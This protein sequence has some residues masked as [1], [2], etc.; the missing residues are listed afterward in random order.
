MAMA[1]PTMLL[2]VVLASIKTFTRAESNIL[3]FGGGGIRA[4]IGT[5]IAISEMDKENLSSSFRYNVGLSGGTWGMAAAVYAKDKLTTQPK[6]RIDD[7]LDNFHHRAEKD[8]HWGEMKQM[9]LRTCINTCHA[10]WTDS[11]RLN[12]M[13][14][15]TNDHK[16]MDF[17]DENLSVQALTK[18]AKQVGLP[19]PKIFVDIAETAWFGRTLNRTG[20]ICVIESPKTWCQF[21]DRTNLASKEHSYE[22]SQI[23]QVIE[24]IKFFRHEN[25]GTKTN[26]LWDFLSYSSSAWAILTSKSWGIVRKMPVRVVLDS[27][28]YD[29]A[30]GEQ[31]KNSKTVRFVDAGTR[32]NFPLMELMLNHRTEASAV[33][34][35]VVFDYGR[36]RKGNLY[37]HLDKCCTYF[38]QESGIECGTMTNAEPDHGGFG[39]RFNIRFQLHANFNRAAEVLYL[40]LRFEDD[41]NIGARYPLK[42]YWKLRVRY[43]MPEEFKTYVDGY[44]KIV[45]DRYIPLIKTFLQH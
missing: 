10:A 41:D 31:N 40:P 22:T 34:K 39:K 44:R 17:P 15:A 14:G 20:G 13:T 38:K 30:E 32:C 28:A 45:K 29:A 18:M 2:F 1:L 6:Q 37:Y 25:V 21:D 9:Y 33:N 26:S 19:Q 43:W 36:K 35:V 23:K 7:M 4:Q 16:M 42:D 27:A 5:M 11:I 8:G 12:L 24:N 3:S